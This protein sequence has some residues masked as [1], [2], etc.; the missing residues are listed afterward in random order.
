M[1]GCSLGPFFFPPAAAHREA[2]P[3]CGKSHP[4]QA[5]RPGWTWLSPA[6]RAG[7]V[8]T[9]WNPSSTSKQSWWK[10]SGELL[11]RVS[12]VPLLNGHFLAQP[13][14]AWRYAHVHCI[15]ALG[16]GASFS[17]H[18]V[19]HDAAGWCAASENPARGGQPQPCLASAKYCV[20]VEIRCRAGRNARAWV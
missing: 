15:S 17:M 18:T 5:K 3:H 20:P 11:R 7:A 10:L 8:P 13:A 9:R 2:Q 6:A 12:T 16:A 14:R 4:P 19:A 1:D